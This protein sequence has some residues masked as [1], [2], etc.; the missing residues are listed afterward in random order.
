MPAPI[1][2]KFLQNPQLAQVCVVGSGMPSAM[3]LCTL[4]ETARNQSKEILAH[5]LLEIIASVNKGLEHHEQ[6]SKLVV[7]PDEWTIANG[8]LTPTLKIK[9]KMI[10]AGFSDNY[11]KWS[12]SNEVVVFV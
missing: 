5:R 1:E 9:R 11:E 6:L 7:F 2:S 10:D 3:A 4:T 12:R 8:L